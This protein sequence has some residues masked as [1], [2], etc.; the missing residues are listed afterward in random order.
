MA[1]ASFDLAII[2]AGPAGHVAAERAGR[3]GKRVLVVE[4]THLGGVCL[5]QG[6]IPTKTLLHSAKL[7]SHAQHGQAFGVSVEGAHYDLAKAMTWK[8]KTVETLRKGVAFQFKKAGVEHVTGTARLAGPHAIDVDGRTFRADR[9]LL[10]TGSA[11]AVLPVP[12]ADHEHVMGSTEALEIAALPKSV[13]IVGG[14][15]IGMEFATYFARLGVKVTV[16]EMLPEIVPLLDAEIAVLL[17]RSL[18]AVEFRLGARVLAYEPGGVK[19]LQDGKE[20]L[21]AADRVLVAVG[22]RPIV[23]GLGLETAGVDFDRK[24]VKVDDRMRTNVPGIWAAGDITGRSML[25]HS[26][27]RMGEVAV[28]D[29]FAAGAPGTAAAPVARMRWNAIPWVVY[30]DPEVAGVGLSAAQAK[31]QGRQVKVAKLD[32]R[33]NARFVAES[34]GTRGMVKVVVDAGSD[35]VLGVQMIGPYASE[36][37]QGAAVM[38]ESELRAKDV[39]EIVFPHPTVSEIVRDALWEIH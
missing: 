33:A 37:V 3:L 17:R 12:G 6:C 32:L 28:A 35:L 7:F 26:A 24:G 1:D 14:G 39:R 27:S 15:Y 23:E 13:A 18:P 38:I 19:F 36:I 29:M 22:R 34:D 5:N 2:G 30:T 16:I 25:A 21:A 10:A 4:K 8:T 31:E 11:A 9:I 20:Q